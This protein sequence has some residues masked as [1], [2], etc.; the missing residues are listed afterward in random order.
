MKVLQICSKPPCPSVDG[1]TLAMHQ[2]SEMLLTH[3]IDLKILSIS[4]AKHNAQQEKI[5]QNYLQKTSF[6][7]VYIDTKVKVPDAFLNLFTNKSYNIERFRNKVFEKRL[8]EILQNNNFEVI[9]LESL[10]VTPYVALIK[11]YS[12]AKIVL[13]AH[14]IEHQIWQKLS[15]EANNLFKRLYLQLLAKRLKN[16]ELNM[17]QHLD[18]ILTFSENDKSSFE[19]FGFKK[20]IQIIPFGSDFN[21]NSFEKLTHKNSVFHLASMDWQPNLE[22]VYWFIKEVWPILKK[23]NKDVVVHLAGRNMPEGIVMLAEERLLISGEIS[24]AKAFMQNHGIMIVPLLTGSG[25]RIKVIEGLSHGKVIV[26]TTKGIEGIDLTDKQDVLI[27]D[28]AHDFAARIDECINNRELYDKIA[29]NAFKFASQ[30][31]DRKLIGDKLIAAL[32]KIVK[33]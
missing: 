22:A 17:L 2:I 24:D 9:L 11:K 25:I 6:E 16:Y 8:K 19:A 27:A 10:Y 5:D 13:R 1:G 29:E 3:N 7:H 28:N 14:N 15:E 20:N 31:L 32:Q 18:A 23:L 33:H 12:T 30:N 4:T 26:S 21:Q